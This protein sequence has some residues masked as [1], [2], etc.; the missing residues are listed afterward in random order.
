M[1][2]NI[3]HII[4]LQINLIPWDLII[5][6]CHQMADL[7]VDACVISTANVMSLQYFHSHVSM[8]IG[9]N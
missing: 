2:L 9:I 1:R 3:K 5:F 4:M 7:H 6:I 8:N